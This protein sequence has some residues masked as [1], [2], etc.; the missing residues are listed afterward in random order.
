MLVF[1]E[2]VPRA[3]K[4]YDAVKTHIL[5]ALQAG[6]RVYARLNGL[7]RDAIAAYLQMPRDRVDELL[8]D[9]PTSECRDFFTA[10]KDELGQWSI[11]AKFKD[12]LFVIDEAHEF[13]VA[14]RNAIA[15][16]I[17]QFFALCG[18]NGMD[19][20]LLSQWYRRLHSSVRARVERKNVFQKLTALGLDGRYNLRQ[21][22]S[23]EPDKF[24]EVDTRVLAYDPKIFPLYHG[25]A[26]GSSNK[27]VY[28]AGGATVWRKLARL[29]IPIAVLLVAAIVFLLH[30]YR[31]GGRGMIKQQPVAAQQ[32]AMQG[33]SSRS[34]VD[35]FHHPAAL[36]SSTQDDRDSES[37][38]KFDTSGMPVEVKYVFD[39]CGKARPRLAAVITV[40]SGLPSGMVEWREQGSKAAVLDRL[41]FDQLRDLG[42]VV[43]VHRY[44]VKLAWRTQ[45]IVVTAWPLDLPPD[46][47]AASPADP[48]S[49]GAQHVADAGAPGS[50]AGYKESSMRQDYL[51]PELA[52]R[53]QPSAHTL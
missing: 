37:V 25:Y 5:P 29:G 23:Y 27:D 1:N 38:Q 50:G 22:H 39:L 18:Q 17:E 14:D 2:G 30:M 11:P 6:R 52:K 8:I 34:A 40:S 3:G 28:K 31:T 42:V 7:N 16:K 32:S 43:Q 21:Y 49:D 47:R 4:S 36:L 45:A 48:V 19:G 9:V 10:E 15:P 26:E 51:P 46:T 53:P 12:A 41:T 24:Q 13:Y 44:G 33:A 20:V 35:T